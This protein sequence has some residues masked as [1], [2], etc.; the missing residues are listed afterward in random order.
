[1]IKQTLAAI[2]LGSLLALGGTPAMAAPQGGHGWSHHEGE[3]SK[4]FKQLD[5]TAQQKEQVKG[6][7]KKSFAS[8]KEEWRALRKQRE[9]FMAMKPTDSGYQAAAQSLADAEGKAASARV[10]RMANVRAQ[11]YGVLTPQQQAKWATLQAERKEHRM[12]HAERR[13]QRHAA[14]KAAPAAEPAAP[15]SDAG[16]ASSATPAAPAAPT[17]PAANQ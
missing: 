2:A 12:K 4:M 8:G 16:A 14:K 6:I 17:A 15:A 7:V 5:L 1:M 11:I 3:H 10:E 9:T 13:A